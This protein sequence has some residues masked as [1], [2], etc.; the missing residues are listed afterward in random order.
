[1]DLDVGYASAGDL[2][3]DGQIAT[4][5]AREIH[6]SEPITLEDRFVSE[7]SCVPF[8]FS[9]LVVTGAKAFLQPA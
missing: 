2:Y 5:V 8:I 4:S 7:S 9:P 6:D 1:L 3:L